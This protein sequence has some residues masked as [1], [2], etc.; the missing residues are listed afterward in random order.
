MTFN[1]FAYM[2]DGS[3]ET[4]YNRKDYTG[5]SSWIDADHDCQN[6][7][8][9]VLIEEAVAHIVAFRGSRPCTVDSGLWLD[10]Y[11]GKEFSSAGDLD[12]DHVVALKDAHI[13]G[14]MYWTKEKKKSYANFL[15]DAR[16][17]MAVSASE[18][19][20][21]GSK[22]PEEYL[23]PDTTFQR[24]YCRIYASIKVNWGLTSDKKQLLFLQKMFANEPHIVLPKLRN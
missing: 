21:K 15:H 24:N 2:S 12:I 16:H 22:G 1:V 13:S 23:P 5:S 6:T 4:K 7:R 17:L 18:N 9:E 19:R 8:A 20:K 10:P 11:T 14:A 3:D